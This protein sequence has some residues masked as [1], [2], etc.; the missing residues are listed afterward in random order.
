MKK[1]IVFTICAVSLLFTVPSH[2]FAADMTADQYVKDARAV[3]KAVS[4]QDVKKMLDAK[5][6][7]VLLD[8][9]DKNELGDGGIPGALNISRGTLEFKAPMMLPDKNA[10]VVVYCGL[11]LRSPLATKT[12]TE[13]GYKNT[14]NMTGGLKAWKEAGYA[15]EK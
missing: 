5:E 1:I 13:M 8:V 4:I 2:G 12:M 3:I 14:F 15:I 11:D 6:A 7:V 9:R 10:R